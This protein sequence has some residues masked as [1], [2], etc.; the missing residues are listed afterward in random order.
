MSKK[1]RP[2]IRSPKNRYDHRAL[3]ANC[4]TN[5]IIDAYDPVTPR[6]RQT[7]QAATAI[8]MYRKVQTGAKS[9]FGGVQAGF[10]IW[11]YQSEIDWEV[12]FDPKKPTPRQT[13]INN[14]NTTAC[15]MLFTLL[16]ANAL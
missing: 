11:E 8:D 16:L 7:N 14:T 15:F 6:L 5:S 12:Y 2:G 9:Q 13:T 1:A 3:S 4:K 10:L